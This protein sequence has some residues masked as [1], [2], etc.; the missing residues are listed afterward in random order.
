MKKT[1]GRQREPPRPLM[2]SETEPSGQISS[3]GV[4]CSAATTK[5]QKEKEISDV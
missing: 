3:F 5:Q 4:F 2:C 1:N